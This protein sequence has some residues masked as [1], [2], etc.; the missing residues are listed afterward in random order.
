VAV[1]ATR[2]AVD[3]AAHDGDGCCCCCCCRCTCLAAA[4]CA[5]GERL[6]RAASLAPRP[7]RPRVMRRCGG[8]GTATASSADGD[9]LT[10]A[11][12]DVGCVSSDFSPTG[13]AA[14]A[15][16]QQSSVDVA[17]STLC[18]GGGV[19]VAVEHEVAAA[20]S[21]AAPPV[22]PCP[23]ALASAGSLSPSHS[24]AASGG[25]A[26]SSNA[27]SALAAALSS[28]GVP[29]PS[30]ATAATG[31][32]GAPLARTIGGGVA[33]SGDAAAAPTLPCR[34]CLARASETGVTAHPM[35]AAAVP[36]ALMERADDA[37][38]AL[39]YESE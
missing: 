35:P 14:G 19:A 17:A 11:A 34:I 28:A 6:I 3:A 39:Q 29:S 26:A 24:P 38:P 25:A 12:P 16:N 30:L 4:A 2:R 31:D 23:P 20:L 27:S 37:L 10:G 36:R 5:R 32:P 21:A 9:V 1:A 18:G 8:A 13:S 22:P 33:H 15:A 7:A